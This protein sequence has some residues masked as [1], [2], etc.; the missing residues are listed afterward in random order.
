MGA[1]L[2]GRDAY[3][4]LPHGP[5]GARRLAALQL[6]VKFSTGAISLGAA[7]IVVLAELQSRGRVRAGSPVRRFVS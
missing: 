6:L 1:T 3:A 7:I 2:F 5:S 4:V